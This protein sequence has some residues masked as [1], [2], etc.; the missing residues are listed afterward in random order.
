LDC[1][2]SPHTAELPLS[3]PALDQRSATTEPHVAST[4]D[5][6]A[7]VWLVGVV[8]WWHRQYLCGYIYNIWGA[9]TVDT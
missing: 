9:R 1:L 5:Q 2:S 4:Q 6:T 3:P 8:V 7:G